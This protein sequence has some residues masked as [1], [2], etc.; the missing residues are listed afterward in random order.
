[1]K[2]VI[3]LISD[4]D[5]CTTAADAR[6]DTNAGCTNTI[7]NYTCACN[8]GYEGDGLMCTGKWRWY[9]N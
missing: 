2:I 8:G 1:M 7:G 9:Y 3:S 6:C 5:E 4:I